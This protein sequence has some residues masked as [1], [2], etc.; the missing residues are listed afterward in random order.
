M[1]VLL[2]QL[3]M[4]LIQ[5]HLYNETHIAKFQSTEYRTHVV[6]DASIGLDGSDLFF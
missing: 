2:P 4:G 1:D 5:V 6:S 3:M